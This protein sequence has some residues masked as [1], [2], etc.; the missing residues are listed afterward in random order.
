M[1]AGLMIHWA[2]AAI[3]ASMHLY[4]NIVSWFK[5]SLLV[6]IQMQCTQ[7]LQLDN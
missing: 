5:S 4:Q 3:R 2:I 1:N 6:M 7:Q